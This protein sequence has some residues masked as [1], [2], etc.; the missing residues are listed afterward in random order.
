MAKTAWPAYNELAWVET[1]VASPEEYAEETGHYC[2]LIKAHSRVET[3]TLLHLGCGAGGNDHTFKKYFKVTGV[4]ISDGMLKI[5]RKRN[6]EAVYIR[7]DMRT[8]RLKE[9]FDAVAIPDSIGYMS[10][11]KD[12]QRAIGTA[13]RHLKPGG[14]LLIVA[15]VRE[16]F[17]ENN[18]VYTGA[19]GD[20]KVAIFENNSALKPGRTTY[21]AVIVYL[22]RR[23][24]RL[25][26]FTE[27]HT[28]GLFP[29]ATWLSLLAA[30][31]LAAK[32]TKRE[33]AY[34]RFIRGDGKYILR[35]FVCSKP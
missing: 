6:P 4:D 31:G 20:V 12:L 23:R 33:H 18:F 34:D 8:F 30:A 24:G 9:R 35:V 1:I 15:L 25:Q 11:P 32:Q 29:Q 21:E 10:A 19:R 3:K 22:I 2:K 26:V 28:Q 13:V 17:Q 7:G 14:V 5:A 16:D 27:R